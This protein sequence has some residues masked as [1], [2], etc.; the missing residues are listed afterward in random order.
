MSIQFAGDVGAYIGI[1]VEGF[2][3][4]W[5]QSPCKKSAMCVQRSPQLFLM[6]RSFLRFRVEIISEFFGEDIR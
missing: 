6:A 4:E 5:S 1:S 3:S 2:A